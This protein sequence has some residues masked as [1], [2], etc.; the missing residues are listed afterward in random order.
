MS[1]PEMEVIGSLYRFTWSD[2]EIVI[3]LDRLHET[4]DGPRAEINVRTTR[5]GVSPHLLDRHINLLSESS[6]KTIEKRLQDRWNGLNWGDMLETVCISTKKEFRKGEPLFTVGNL[7]S[8]E[9]PKHRLYPLLLEAEANLIFGSGGSGKSKFA[10]LL[11]LLIQSGESYC[12]L[13][14]IQGNVLYLEYETCKEELDETIKMLTRGMPAY[15][16]DVNISYR[17]CSQPLWTDVPELLKKIAECDASIVVIDSVGSACGGEPE[18]AEVV[19]NYFMALRALKV[20][21]LS[22]DHVA[23]KA[24]GRPFGSVYKINNARSVWELKKIQEPGESGS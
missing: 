6:H 10:D 17:Y 5:Q 12:G 23:H 14:P 7:P 13:K 8:R 11:S 2:Y 16:E 9:R 4:K 24:E 21:T 19:L 20:T 3:E 1:S 15:G 18:S 22:I